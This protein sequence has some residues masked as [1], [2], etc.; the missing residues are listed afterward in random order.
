MRCPFGQNN[1]GRVENVAQPQDG[2]SARITHQFERLAEFTSGAERMLIHQDDAGPERFH[3]RR[4]QRGAKRADFGDRN[5]QTARG[6]FVVGNFAQRRKL[7]HL[8]LR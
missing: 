1:G 8:D 2:G 5:A 6:V 4:E 3:G 7:Q